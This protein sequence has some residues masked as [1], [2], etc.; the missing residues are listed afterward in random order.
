M[1]DSLQKQVTGNPNH[2]QL[3]AGRGP[4]DL[5][6]SDIIFSPPVRFASLTGR[7]PR[8]INHANRLLYVWAVCGRPASACL[9]IKQYKKRSAFKI[10]RVKSSAAAKKPGAFVLD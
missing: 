6:E 5:G 2:Y 8:S 7:G 4:V 9:T 1:A 3:D 10:G